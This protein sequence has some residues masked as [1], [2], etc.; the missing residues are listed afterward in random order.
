MEVFGELR[1][2]LSGHPLTMFVDYVTNTAADA[3]E[4]GFALGIAYRR[5]SDIGTWNLGYSYQDLE[6]NAVVGAFTDS[7]FAGGTSDGSGHTLRAGYALP[8]GLSLALRYVIG[9]RG[10][11]AGNH[12]DYDRLQADLSFSY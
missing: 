1:L 11:A 8:G 3:Y 10:E 2:D 7:D 9:D 5:N 6:A 12:R 4:D